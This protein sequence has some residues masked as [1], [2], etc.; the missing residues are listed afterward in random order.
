MGRA[1]VLRK[2]SFRPFFIAWVACWISWLVLTDNSG[3]REMLVG[4][5]ASTI[6]LLAIAVFVRK[7]KWT[8]RVRLKLL[9]EAIH[10]PPQLFTDTELLAFTVV[11]RM[12]GARPASGIMAVPFRRGA[13]TPSSRMRRALA[14][15]YVTVTP[16]TLV[17]GISQDPELFVLHSIVPKPLPQFMACMGAEPESES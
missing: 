11:R 17:L 7:T 10:V 12:F 6:S 4:A 3:W 2:L 16:N 15:T 8:F 13:N 1:V 5:C 14:I 9:K